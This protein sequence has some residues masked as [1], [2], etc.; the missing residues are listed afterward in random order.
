MPNELAM[1]KITFSILLFLTVYAFITTMA[2]RSSSKALHLHQAVSR[3]DQPSHRPKEPTFRRE[4]N[5]TSPSGTNITNDRHKKIDDLMFQSWLNRTPKIQDGIWLAKTNR[6][7]PLYQNAFKSMNLDESKA[8]DALNIILERE[9]K[10]FDLMAQLRSEG[11]S[12]GAKKFA[13]SYKNENHIAEV[14]LRHLLDDEQY[15]RLEKVE[16]EILA[17]TMSEAANI[18]KK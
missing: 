16:K 4:K 5:Q 9:R 7:A 12:N 6:L 10:Q 13:E 1:K 14:E 11:F 18:M 8:K 2:H 17:Q 3:N 15:D